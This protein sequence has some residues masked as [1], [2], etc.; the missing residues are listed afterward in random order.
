MLSL[1]DGISGGRLALERL[2]IVID[3]YVASE[4][5]KNAIKVTQHHY[6][7]TIQ[8]GDITKLE[9][10]NG[11]LR[12]YNESNESYQEMEFT[13]DII[14]GGSP[15]QDFSTAKA[16]LTEKDGSTY[17]LKGE[18]SRL[19]YD[20]L[21]LLNAIKPKYFLL[22]N[23]NMRKDSKKQLDDYLG[24]EGL[25][26]NSELFSYQKRPRVYWTNIPF[27]RN[28]NDRKVSFQDYKED[29]GNEKLD[30]TIPNKTKTRINMWNNGKG[31]EKIV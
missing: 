11:V 2:G 24:V 26:I 7:D 30:Y 28:I 17:G 20:Y 18:K 19:F 12:Y 3:T 25:L 23:V 9:W 15:C 4:V 14:I 22:E 29:E 6:P 27:E 31:R 13:P 10:K 1:F 16:H 5:S 8:V 21:R